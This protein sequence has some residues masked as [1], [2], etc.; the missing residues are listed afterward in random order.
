[1]IAFEEIAGPVVVISPHDD[2]ALIGVGG[3]LQ[4]LRDPRIVIL[5]NG[6]LGY[7]SEPEQATIVERRR[8]EA[9]AAYGI[10]GIA[11]D[12][13]DWAGFPDLC[14]NNY[15]CW[16]TVTG[17]EGGY[18]AVVRLIRGMGA[19]GLLFATASDDHPDHRAG[20]DLATAA[21]G[22]AADPV[23]PDLGSPVALE[24]VA[25]YRVWRDLDCEG[26]HVELDAKEAERK[27]RAL[28]AF[29]SQQAL[30]EL[31]DRERPDLYDREELV[32]RGARARAEAARA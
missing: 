5:T 17:Q 4:R 10:L 6:E 29:E 28:A 3:L 13:I 12:A 16:R 22:F 14:L 1:M 11:R 15:R 32:R 20:A 30:L 9:E 24:A 31:L 2:D 21:A 25:E 27:R 26:E 23:F 18:Q 8:T 7:G 19:N